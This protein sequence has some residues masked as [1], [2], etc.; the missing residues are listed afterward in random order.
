MPTLSGRSSNPLQHNPTS[1]DQNRRN[2]QRLVQGGPSTIGGVTPE[3]PFFYPD[4]SPLTDDAGNLYY[5]DDGILADNA[6]NLYYPGGNYLA[7]DT[8]GYLYY[9]SGQVLAD[10]YSTLYYGDGFQL[11]TYDGRL[12]YSNGYELADASGN[13]YY[14]NGS[15]LADASGNLYAAD[16]EL[17]FNPAGD[18]QVGTLPLTTKGDLLTIDGSGAFARLPA[19]TNGQV[20]EA[21]SSATTGLQWVTGGGGG[22]PN[23]ADKEV[24]TG[25]INGSNTV[26]TLANTPA[27]GSEQVI[28]NGLM[29]YPGSGNDYMIVTNTITFLTGA[30]PQTGDRLFV[31]YRY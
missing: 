23:F 15:T 18:L 16:G 28:V 1:L 5:P 29:L 19:G 10:R 17:L 8:L 9:P 31:N 4:G 21:N 30:I 12:Y 22:G 11:A 27:S 7:D 24:P 20:L 6:G 3:G 13:L 25:L 26:F 14:G 2:W